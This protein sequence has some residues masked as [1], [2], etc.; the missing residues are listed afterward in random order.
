[1]D[2][3]TP[4]ISRPNGLVNRIIIMHIERVDNIFT[5]DFVCKTYIFMED[6]MLFVNDL[7]AE[8]ME[9]VKSKYRMDYMMAG[10][11]VTAWLPFFLHRSA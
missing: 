7:R 9:S 2:I 5:E 10:S 6:F 1:M 11:C 4:R 3:R 8:A